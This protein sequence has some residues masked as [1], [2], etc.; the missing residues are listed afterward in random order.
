ME[1][2]REIDEILITEGVESA[3]SD[4]NKKIQVFEKGR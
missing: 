1:I 4:E 3:N 2:L